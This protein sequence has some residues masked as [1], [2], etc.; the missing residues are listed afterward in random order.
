MPS[1][2]PDKRSKA[3]PKNCERKLEN[4]YL[5]DALLNN[6]KYEHHASCPTNF[7]FTCSIPLAFYCVELN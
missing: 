7:T 6:K 5:L 1:E 4:L 3:N 2:Q